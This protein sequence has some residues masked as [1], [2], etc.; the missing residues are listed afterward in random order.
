LSEERIR[1]LALLAF[2]WVLV[3]LDAP[4]AAPNPVRMRRIAEAR[5]IGSGIWLVLEGS[6][7]LS[8]GSV[9]FG[10]I[11]EGRG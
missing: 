8:T 10:V 7:N 6:R 4:I 1:L 5:R 2:W 9:A 11:A 3:G